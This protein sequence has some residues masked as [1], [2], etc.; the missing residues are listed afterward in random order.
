MQALCLYE[1][2][3][4]SPVGQLRLIANNKALLALCWL[5]D[6]KTP[7]AAQH[8]SV[9]RQHD[10]LLQAKDELQQYFALT[11]QTFD[12]P[13]E[14]LYGTAF[15]K[16]V[17]QA[18][19]MIPPAQT[20]HYAALAEQ[21]GR[22]RAVRAVATAVANNPLSIVVPCHRVV[23]K[24][25]DLCGFAGGLAAKQYLLDLEQKAWSLSS[26]QAIVQ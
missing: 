10:I 25:G 23:G 12:L 1:Q 6:V 21:I 18:L 13:I 15:Q 17:W 5:D 16:S 24:R 3:I 20:W 8:Y 7:Y 14:F 26:S 19:M 2:T 4:D 22:A 9:A 11:R